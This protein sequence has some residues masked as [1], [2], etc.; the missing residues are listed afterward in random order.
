MVDHSLFEP[1]SVIWH[2]NNVC[3]STCKYCFT[4]AQYSNT[5]I[6]NNCWQEIVKRINE[7]KSIKRVSIIGGEPL[8]SL[9]LPRILNHLRKDIIIN[10]DS[11]LTKIKE[12]WNSS[13]KKAYFC[14]T[15]DSI[16]EDIHL[17]T[18]GHSSKKT[19]EGIKFLINKGIKVMVVIVVNKYNIDSLENTIR[20]LISI[21]VDK[22]GISRTRMSGRALKVGYDYFYP[23][24]I[25][26]FKNNTF[27]ILQ[28]LINEYGKDKFIIYNLWHDSKFFDLGYTYEPSCKCA[29]FRLCID[30]DGFAYP[31][32][33][34]PFYWDLFK[35][36]YALERPNVKES[37][38]K[39]IFD[40]SKLFKFF[41]NKMLFYP[42]GCE[43]CKYKEKCNH[44]CRFYSFL[45]SGNLL[46]KDVVCRADCLYDVIGYKYYSPLFKEGK[47][48]INNKIAKYLN[49]N[50]NFL[51][52]KI[53][54]LGCGGGVWTFYLEGLG[55]KVIGIDINKTMILMAQEFKDIY[56]KKSSFIWGDVLKYNFDKADSALLLDN[57]ISNFSKKELEQLIN[58]LKDKIKAL[59]IE[60]SESKYKNETYNYKFNGFD[61]FEKIEKYKGKLK[62]LF[63]NKQTGAEFEIYTYPWSKEEL[64]NLLKK[65]GNI[66]EENIGNSIVIKLSF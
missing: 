51:G 34:M 44:G 57:I 31:C 20:Y 63:K 39:N 40:D 17:K 62:R 14:T 61:I 15:I 35:E 10:I 41:R 46:A 65:Y 7:E 32:E 37:S 55:K 54:D 58:K 6:S 59:I 2:I 49:K 47:E 30:W 56:D 19:I 53:Y 8:L 27:S 24:S 21:G 29:L 42:V 23:Q 38:I 5:F 18:R 66:S 33:L 36:A 45:I 60:F 43:N 64:I 50:N 26:D 13:F 22:I 12:I 1:I 52:E 3:N 9:D 16:I 4:N 28:K 48:R 11:N 25:K